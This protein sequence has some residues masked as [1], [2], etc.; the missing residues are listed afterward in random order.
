MGKKKSQK[1][2]REVFKPL[3]NDVIVRADWISEDKEL[4]NLG[5]WYLSENLQIF[6]LIFGIWNSFEFLVSNP[7]NL[8]ALLIRLK[9]GNPRKNK[10]RVLAS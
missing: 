10:A 6:V 9:Q 5:P 3:T 8:H 4:W 2:I 7:S 1:S